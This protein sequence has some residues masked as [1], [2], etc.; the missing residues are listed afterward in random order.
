MCVL[1]L[2]L[3]TARPSHYELLHVIVVVVSEFDNEIS[4]EEIAG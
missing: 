4:S 1:E 2:Y 3:N